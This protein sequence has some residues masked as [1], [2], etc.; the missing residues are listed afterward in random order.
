MK[1]FVLA[2]LAFASLWPAMAQAAERRLTAGDLRAMADRGALLCE[3]W[4]EAGQRC[5]AVYRWNRVDG[6][7]TET[8][9][10]SASNTPPID[11][12][13]QYPIEIRDDQVCSTLDANRT[14]LLV[15]ANGR[16]LTSEE[17]APVR[18]ALDT[19]YAPVNGQT[20]CT[21][22]FR[23]DA[24]GLLRAEATLNGQPRTEL[25]TVFKPLE[26]PPLPRMR[27]VRQPWTLAVLRTVRAVF[28]DPQPPA[29]AEAATTTAA[30]AAP[31]SDAPSP[32]GTLDAAAA[33]SP[34]P[35]PAAAAAGAAAEP[36]PS[37]SASELSPAAQPAETPAA[38]LPAAA[39][40]AVVQGAVPA[41]QR[42]SIWAR[43]RGRCASQR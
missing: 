1:S 33:T 9:L 25:N 15:L 21:A 31:T 12:A 37:P 30:A 35:A 24:R 42:C 22:F 8:R 18:A 28:P 5:D 41:P 20:V 34:A 19:I 3:R 26:G 29:A 27:P 32:T 4:D 10:E 13:L 14:S 39:E 38:A 23:D 6:E 36:T 2:L 7:L 11:T 43:L 16:E 17:A 40:P